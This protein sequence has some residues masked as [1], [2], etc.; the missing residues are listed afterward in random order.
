M[1]N[2]KPTNEEKKDFINLLSNMSDE[3]INEYI[4]KNGKN[5]SKNKLFVFLWDNLKE[6]G[7]NKKIIF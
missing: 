2:R 1:K 5:N 4:K 7:N 6:D 3:E